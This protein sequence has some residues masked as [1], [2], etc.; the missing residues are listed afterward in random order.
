M[1]GKEFPAADEINALFA[2]D[3]PDEVWRKAEAIVRRINPDYDF[4]RARAIFDDVKVLFCG[5]YPGY[6]PVRTPYHNQAHTLHVFMCAVRLMHGVHVSGISMSDED[7]TL[8]MMAALMHDIGYA[9][10]KGE[11]SG[12][13]AQYTPSHVTRGIAFMHRYVAAQGFPNGW[14]QRLEPL[15][16]STDPGYPFTQI[17]F[18]DEHARLLGQ[19]VAT[20]DLVGQMADRT[21]LEKLLFLYLE[22]KEA[23]FGN[24]RNVHDMLRQT[25]RFYEI[26]KEKLDGLYQGLYLKLSEH[27]RETMGVANNYYLESVE[28]NIAYLD[29]VTRH[30]EAEHLEM[31][32]RAGI[33]D[34]AKTMPGFQS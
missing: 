33:A 26:T 8:V 1:G 28:K 17:P 12:T 23:N 14:A 5:D 2:N 19:L 29:E 3:E 31:L 30:E 24:Y 10:T 11:E 7:V 18:A 21:Y 34:K 32:K 13:G 27:F 6:A 25:R 22:F 15:I 4:L 20:A 16:R 9:Q